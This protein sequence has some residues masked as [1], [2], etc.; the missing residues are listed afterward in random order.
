MVVAA[1]TGWVAAIAWWAVGPVSVL[2]ALVRPPVALLLLLGGLLLALRV[3]GSFQLPGWGVLVLASALTCGLLGTGWVVSGQR[4]LLGLGQL[5]IM[6]LAPFVLGAAW[7]AGL[8]I[9]AGLE[10]RGLDPL[11]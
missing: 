8:V 2:P 1:V 7:L 10:R 3:A 6:G 5:V 9:R 4:D 11:P